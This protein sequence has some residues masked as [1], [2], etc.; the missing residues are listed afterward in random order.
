M[1]SEIW[2]FAEQQDGKI[3]NVAFELLA[4]GSKLANSLKASLCAVCLGHNVEETDQ[5]VACGADKIY[6]IDDPSLAIPDEDL[7]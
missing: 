4:E 3:K 2:V 5:L 1:D 7:Y 6:S